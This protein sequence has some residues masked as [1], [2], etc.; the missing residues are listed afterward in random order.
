MSKT[1]TTTTTTTY[2]AA[3]LGERVYLRSSATRTYLSASPSPSYGGTC[4]FHG[5]T[6]GQTRTI[7]LTQDD[8]AA[9]H[10]IALRRVTEAGR[11]MDPASNWVAATPEVLSLLLTYS[12]VC[13][14]REYVTSQ[15]RPIAS[16]AV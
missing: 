12:N 16:E 2:C 5:H 8:Y 14:R 6:R 3:V 4:T 13:A 10:E 11:S 9:L 1:K 15:P 7:A